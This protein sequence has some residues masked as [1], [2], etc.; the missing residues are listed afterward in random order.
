[1]VGLFGLNFLEIQLVGGNQ[2]LAALEHQVSQTLFL[3]VMS[4]LQQMKTWF[5]IILAKLVP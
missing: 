3:L 5:A 1:M 4:H 2:Q